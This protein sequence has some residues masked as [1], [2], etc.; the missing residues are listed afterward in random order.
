[1]RQEVHLKVRHLCHPKPSLAP[2]RGKTVFHGNGPWGS[3]GWGPLSETVLSDVLHCA[4]LGGHW[5]GTT[6]RAHKHGSPQHVPR[7]VKTVSEPPLHGSS[8]ESS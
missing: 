4:P 3:H 1:M 5:A 7:V 8:S 2:I 6:H